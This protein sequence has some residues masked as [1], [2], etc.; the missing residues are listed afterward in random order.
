MHN[1][2]S[3]ESEENS[4]KTTAPTANKE[5]QRGDEVRNQG[6]QQWRLGAKYNGAV[7]RIQ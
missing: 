5:D 3:L 2:K 6:K 1:N 7:D 4:A